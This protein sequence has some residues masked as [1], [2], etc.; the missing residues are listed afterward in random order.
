MYAVMRAKMINLEAH[1][2]P[3]KHLWGDRLCIAPANQP[4]RLK[5]LDTQFV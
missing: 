2:I 1:V 4:V 3:Q 5:I